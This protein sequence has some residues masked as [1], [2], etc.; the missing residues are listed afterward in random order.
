MIRLV[1]V[2]KKLKKFKKYDPLRKGLKF[3]EQ[4]FFKFRYKNIRSFFIKNFEFNLFCVWLGIGLY[5]TYKQN[6]NYSE[7]IRLISAGIAT[8]VVVDIITYVG[9]KI[10]TKVKVDSFKKKKKSSGKGVDIY[11]EDKFSHNKLAKKRKRNAKYGLNGYLRDISF[12]GLQAAI[13]FVTINSIVFYGLY[14]NIKFF[15]KEKFGWE[16]SVNFFM[17]AGISQLF[18]MM[19]A[20]PLENIKTR[21]Q[22]SNFNYN[23][24]F[25]YYK[26][27]IYGKPLDVVIS[28]IK[29]EYSGFV[30][31]LILYV[32]YESITFGI[33]ETL[34]KLKKTKNTQSVSSSPQMEEKEIHEVDFSRVILASVISGL[35]AAVVTNPIDVYQ[36]NKQINP[37]FS[38]N[39]LNKENIMYGMK[40]RIYFIT[41]LNLITFIFLESIGPKY[42]RVRLE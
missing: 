32:V 15:L 30:S 29:N 35:V 16:G 5:Y 40:E 7:T 14:K 19:I 39:Q 18:A 20:F 23:S 27:L 12:R 37:K 8:H 33:Y 11:F 24:L 9:D 31:H 4:F 34:M 38:V 28:N 25:S 36:I 10:N 41:L 3:S 6:K 22:A 42:Y 26:N 21:M 1:R 2:F 13:I 17:A